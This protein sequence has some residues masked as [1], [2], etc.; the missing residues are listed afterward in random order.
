M[1]MS[2]LVMMGIALLLLGQWAK[3]I[4]ASLWK[5][6]CLA[7]AILLAIQPIVAALKWLGGLVGV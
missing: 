2:L 7:C 1:N 4:G 6:S 3:G 5:W